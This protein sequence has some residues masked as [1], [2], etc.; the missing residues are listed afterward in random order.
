MPSSL[1]TTTAAVIL[2]L[3]GYY[4]IPILWAIVTTP[5]RRLPGPPNDSLFWGNTK[6]L[7]EADEG[8]LQDEWIA[9]YGP[10]ISYR[11][12]FGVCFIRISSRPWTDRF[13]EDI[14]PLDYR[15]QVTR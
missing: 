7:R 4:L 10:T 3:L 6:R 2:L 12:I 1:V 9:Q 5:L 15:H 13:P 11:G 14:A 8:V